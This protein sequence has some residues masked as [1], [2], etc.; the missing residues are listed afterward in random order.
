MH[1]VAMRCMGQVFATDGWSGQVFYL[2]N[3]DEES[4]IYKKCK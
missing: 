2:V 4:M 1:F 3:L